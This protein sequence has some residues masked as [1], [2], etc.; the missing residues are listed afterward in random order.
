MEQAFK[1]RWAILAGSLLWLHLASAAPDQITLEAQLIWA[2]NDPTSP[3][4]RHMAAEDAVV[5]KLQGLGLKWNKF[6]EDRGDRQSLS[7][8]AGETRKVQ[9]SR[10]LSI[11]VK[12]LG[13][14]KIEVSTYG[15][16]V[17]VNRLT[18]SLPPS[19]LLAIG[20]DVGGS[21]AWY[22]VLKRP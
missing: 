15:K 20:G 7:L 18:Q 14:N 10:D 6:F 21:S 19:E 3:N 12:Y 11:E 16:G 1:L 9:M 2:T 8:K 13:N 17:L 5:R 4:P 22:V